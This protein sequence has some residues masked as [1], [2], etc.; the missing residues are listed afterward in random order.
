MS[1]DQ[2]DALMKTNRGESV[3][4]VMAR[5]KEAKPLAKPGAPTGNQ[6]AVRERAEKAEPMS[7]KN[8]IGNAKVVSV[9][10]GGRTADYLTARIARDR[11]DVLDR[12]KAG[13]FRSVRA[14]AI[15]AGIVPDDPPPA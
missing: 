5:A 1:E 9:S 7:G 13:E 10:S 14:A 4:T 8:N 2:A 15:E 6:N 12:M 3:G 11:P